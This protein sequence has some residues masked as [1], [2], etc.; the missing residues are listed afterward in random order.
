[1]EKLLIIDDSDEIRTQL[2]WGLGEEYSILSAPDATTAL[3]LFKQNSPRVA[4]LDLGLPPDPEG[5]SEG[6]RCLQEMLQHDPTAKVIVLTGNDH[7]ENALKA[8]KLGAYDYYQKPINLEEFKVIIKRAH[9]LSMLEQENRSLHVALE[10]QAGPVSGMIGQC[11]EMQS[12][13]SIMRKVASSEASVLIQGESGTGKELVARAIH[14]MSPRKNGPFIAINCGAIPETLLESELFGHEKGSYTGAQAQVQGTVEYA[15]K[16]T[17]FLDEIGELPALLQVKLLR[18]LQEKTIQRIGGRE[19]IAVDTRILAATNREI[20]KEIKEARF[21]EDL[22]YRLGVITIK[23]P[24]LRERKE[25]IIVLAT[26]FLKR[27]CELQNKKIRGFNSAAVAVMENYPWPG[28]V[29]ELEN[30]IQRAIIMCEGPMVE[31]HDLGFDAKPA[32]QKAFDYEIK[33][34]KAAR[35][36]VEK[37]MMLAA[38]DT[39]R[40]NVARAAEELGVSRPT[41][42]DLMKKY[43]LANNVSQPESS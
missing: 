11:R 30:K 28:N 29:R 27:Y 35:E 7:R 26:Y 21:R 14:D 5:V 15:Q 39:Q 20:E 10:R 22:Y 42:Y 8:V 2:K 32:K 1:M 40:G 31:P 25:D 3:S 4:T 19:T 43:G 33:T 13:F 18:F 38:L 17:L 9:H 16:G 12:V 24:S 36:R 34:L 23:V 37:E 41:L 6:F